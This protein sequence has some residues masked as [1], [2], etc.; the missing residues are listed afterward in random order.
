MYCKFSV[1][2]VI[3]HTLLICKDLYICNNLAVASIYYYYY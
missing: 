3:L 1:D 2:F